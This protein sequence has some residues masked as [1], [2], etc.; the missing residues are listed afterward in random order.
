[1]GETVGDSLGVKK[2]VSS[3]RRRGDYRAKEGGGG[4]RA[5]RWCSKNGKHIR[6]GNGDVDWI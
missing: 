6:R 4:G 5:W 2:A 1:M 3:E